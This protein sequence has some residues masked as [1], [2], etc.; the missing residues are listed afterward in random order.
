MRGHG[1]CQ[2]HIHAA[3]VTF[4][5]R[6]QEFFNLGKSDNL[7]KLPFDFS[8]G[9]SENR[10][11]KRNILASSQLRMETCAHLQQTRHASPDAY[12]SLGRLGNPAQN[13]QQGGFPSSVS[14]D[15]ADNLAAGHFE[16]HVF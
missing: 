13:F 15:N 7:I 6:I 8:S 4:H 2:A 3:A 11:I 14:T 12:P 1:K 16:G 10:A 9:H 5:W